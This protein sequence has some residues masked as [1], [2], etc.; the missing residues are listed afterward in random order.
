[1][2]R[3]RRSCL[4]WL[5]LSIV[6]ISI[7]TACTGETRY[8]GPCATP[9][10]V[11]ESEIV[12][13]WQ[14]I[15]SR[16]MSPG[17]PRTTASFDSLTER[18]PVTGIEEINI[19]L[20]GTYVQSFRQEGTI[21]ENGQNSWRLEEEAPD[22]PKL[23]MSNLR[24]YAY[25][26]QNAAGPLYLEPQMSDLLRIQV[27][28]EEGNKP[29]HHLDVSYPGDG[30]IYLYPRRCGGKLVLLQMVSDSGDPDSLGVT[31]PVFD[32]IVD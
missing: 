11:D 24:Y 10:K 12:G 20:D 3:F 32:R 2:R 18:Y 5:V 29:Y 14:I 22:A 19:Q 28:L 16:Y 17:I 26:L 25:G 1:M 4:V 6:S 27:P 15:Y 8:L 21:Y 13:R 31:H 7:V 9:T 30:Y 23:V